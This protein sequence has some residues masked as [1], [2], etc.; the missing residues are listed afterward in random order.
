[1]TEVAELAPVLEGGV[2]RNEVESLLPTDK[3]RPDG[4]LSRSTSFA[5]E[6]LER[7]GQVVMERL[8]DASAINLDLHSRVRAISHITWRSEE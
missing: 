5:L 2:A 6:R 8:A 7:R 3:R 1:M 4:H